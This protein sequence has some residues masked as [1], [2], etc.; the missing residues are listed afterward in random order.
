MAFFPHV[1]AYGGIGVFVVAVIVR[2]IIWLRMPM[3]MR[4]ELY[5][6]AHEPGR[7]AYGGSYLEEVDWWK[8]PRE[9]SLIGELKVMVPEILFLV[10][11]KEHNPKMWLRSFPFHFGLYLV[12]GSTALMMGS[13]ILAAA[14]PDLLA[15]G[16][17]TVLR[18]VIQVTGI[19][20]LGLSLVGALG[21]L[22][23]RITAADLRDFTTPAD[24]FNLVF[25]VVAFGLALVHI[26]LVDPSM[27]ISMAFVQGLVTF[28]PLPLAG[29]VSQVILSASTIVLLAL[30]V[31][32]IPLTH[33]SHFI[34]KY[35]A[36]H[37]IRWNDAPNLRGGKQEASIEELLKQPVTWSAPHIKAEGR[38]SWLD[39]ATEEMK[40]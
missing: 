38:K 3:H 1:V 11:L 21:L 15:G 37:A 33:M 4:W 22:Q 12:I 10:A 26:V 27:A 30:L 32:Y 5:P 7:A 19:G 18:L 24:L 9:T 40:K 16:L 23:R 31:A 13:G 39:L 35:F 20:G 29:D 6:V 34:G 17:G 8:K 2:S 36:Y 25:F 28:Q 14:L